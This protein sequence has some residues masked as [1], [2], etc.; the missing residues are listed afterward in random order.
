MRIKRAWLVVLA[1]GTTSILSGCQPEKG[2]GSGGTTAKERAY[3]VTCDWGLTKALNAAEAKAWDRYDLNI[4]VKG[5]PANLLVFVYNPDGKLVGGT[6]GNKITA[7]EMRLSRVG[8]T[9][10]DVSF[11]LQN[12][13]GAAIEGTYTV[14]VRKQGSDETVATAK[15]DR[16]KGDPAS[17]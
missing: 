9:A 1:L 16:K 5:E 8:S 15:V 7:D 11:F 13:N 12:G 14:M 10:I 17:R 6:D 3:Q 4:T 2:T